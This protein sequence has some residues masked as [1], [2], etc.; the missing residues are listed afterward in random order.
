MTEDGFEKLMDEILGRT[1]AA[2]EDL[3]PELSATLITA[4]GNRWIKHPSCCARYEERNNAAYNARLRE[5]RDCCSAKR[6]N[7]EWS[8][9]FRC[10]AEPF[11]PDA[12]LEIKAEIEVHPWA[13][14]VRAAWTESHELWCCSDRWRKVLGYKAEVALMMTN[15]ERA[16]LDSLGDEFTVYRGCHKDS[17]EGLSWSIKR[18]AAEYF[19]DRIRAYSLRRIV[20]RR[21]KR[22]DVIAFVGKR[23]EAE[24]VV[25]P[26]LLMSTDG[27]GDGLD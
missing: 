17:I 25:F 16:Y 6:A 5:W 20:E 2:P 19:A 1:D 4:G 9:Y 27:Q 15:E 22:S 11:W 21:V 14:A 13:Q 26:E 24:V 7:K 12:L 8:E 18:S 3:V 10:Y 23:E